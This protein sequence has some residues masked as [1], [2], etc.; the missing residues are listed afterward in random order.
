MSSDVYEKLNSC[1]N[2]APVHYQ[3]SIS[4]ID[5]CSNYYGKNGIEEVK[6]FVVFDTS[7]H[8]G[9]QPG[10]YTYVIDQNIVEKQKFD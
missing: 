4:V 9:I 10:Y 3:A 6:Q 8:S 5:E 2:F 1:L 7:F